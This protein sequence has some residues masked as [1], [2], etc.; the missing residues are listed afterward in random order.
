MTHNAYYNN[1][2]NLE[3]RY[4]VSTY[5]GNSH[6]RVIAWCKLLKID[7]YRIKRNDDL[8]TCCVSLAP[9][10]KQNCKFFRD[11]NNQSQ[12]SQFIGDEKE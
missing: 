12:L 5:I 8:P 4:P 2:Q 10:T 11:K 3:W 6:S 9:Y 1:C 7:V